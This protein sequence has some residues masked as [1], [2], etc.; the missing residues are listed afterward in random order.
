MAGI[1]PVLM[2]ISMIIKVWNSYSSM[3]NTE[4]EIL[5]K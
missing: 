4:A 3:A 1:L 2:D 5:R